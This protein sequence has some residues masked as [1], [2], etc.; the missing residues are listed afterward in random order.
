MVERPSVRP[1]VCLS[2][3]STAEAACGGFAVGRIAIDNLGRR[4]RVPA[5]CVPADV[6]AWGP[7]YKI[8][9]HNLTITFTIMPNL[10]STYDGRVIY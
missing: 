1:S 7:I 8:S 3:R 10:R 9:Y 4:R 2:H 5:T 6:G